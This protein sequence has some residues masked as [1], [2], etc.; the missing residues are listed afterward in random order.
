MNSARETKTMNVNTILVPTDFS[1]SSEAALEYATLLARGLDA[2][3]LIAH[4]M[5]TAV[6]SG[7]DDD[8]FDP[9]ETSLHEKLEAVRPSDPHV[10]YEHRFGHGVPSHAIVRLAEHE[11]VDL[12]VM[13]AHGETGRKDEPMGAVAS[14]VV[15]ESRCP[16]LTFSA[17]HTAALST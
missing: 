16:V 1:P 13:G 2:S 10:A 7:G 14:R 17:A 11:E 8:L 12:I 15:L 3:L 6:I 4:I 9:Q 5:P